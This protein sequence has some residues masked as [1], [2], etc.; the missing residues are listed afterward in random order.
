MKQAFAAGAGAC[1]VLAT[2]PALA[3]DR[4]DWLLRWGP[5]WVLPND[6][7]GE[8]RPLGV[9]GVS[10]D[11]AAAFGISLTYMMSPHLGLEL[12]AATPFRHDINSSGDLAGVVPGRIG[13]T[14]H[15]PPTLSLQYHFPTP[16]NWRPYVGAGINYT[17][18]FDSETRG[19][20]RDAGYDRLSLDDSWGWSVQAG[21]DVDLGERWFLGAT[22][23]YMAI[24][25]TATASGG[26]GDLT[27][28]VDIDPWVLKIGAGRRF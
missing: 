10:V 27:V 4:G 26:P 13:T 18:F 15:L 9:E 24:D 6:D 25:T 22:A 17:Y 2:T 1:L 19:E 3:L 16:G 12:L 8:V 5:T 14:K 20:L 7:S 23:Y 28:D 21:L 11:D